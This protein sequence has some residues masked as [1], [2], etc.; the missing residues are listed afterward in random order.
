MRASSAAWNPRP[1]RPNVRV[2]PKTRWSKIKPS[3]EVVDL[4]FG[5]K[6]RGAGFPACRF[7]G[8]SSPASGR[9]ESRPTGR[10]E[11]LPHASSVA[12][13]LPTSEFRLIVAKGSGLFPNQLRRQLAPS[14]P[15]KNVTPGDVIPADS[16]PG[17][18]GRESRRPLACARNAPFKLACSLQDGNYCGKT[19][20]VARYQP[21]AADRRRSICDGDDARCC[22]RSSTT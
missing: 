14:F 7:A 20:P 3:P 13:F 22:R 2:D 17:K 12:P 19:G 4:R 16:K 10:Q 6:Q 5:G 15:R 9:L 11:C 18:P 8:L 1:R 21:R